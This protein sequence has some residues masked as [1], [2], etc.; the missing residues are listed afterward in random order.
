MSIPITH[1]EQF[2]RDYENLAEE[3]MEDPCRS[4]KTLD[5]FSLASISRSLCYIVDY[6]EEEKKKEKESKK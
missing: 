3:I 4:I 6:L 5:S 2:E 1:V